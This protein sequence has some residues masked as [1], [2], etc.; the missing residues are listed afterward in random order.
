MF[1]MHLIS[2]VIDGWQGCEL[3]P[4]AKLNVK[5]QAPT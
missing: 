4:P 5:K 3:S 1:E 2:V